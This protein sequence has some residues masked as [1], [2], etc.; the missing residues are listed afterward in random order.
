[1]YFIKHIFNFAR[2]H[3]EGMRK[4]SVL[5]TENYAF[6][7]VDVLPAEITEP[8]EREKRQK[9]FEKKAHDM[10]EQMQ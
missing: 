7:G 9:Q 8:I 4:L 3:K 2:S 6:S 5:E 10:M 1:M